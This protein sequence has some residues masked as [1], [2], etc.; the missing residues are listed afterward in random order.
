MRRDGRVR[1]GTEIFSLSKVEKDEI[2]NIVKAYDF[3]RSA[4]CDELEMMVIKNTI[5]LIIT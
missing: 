3:K 5:D 4:D 1:H 2:L